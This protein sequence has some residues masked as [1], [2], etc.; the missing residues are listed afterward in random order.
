VLIEGYDAG[1]L[2]MTSYALGCGVPAADAIGSTEASLPTDV[3]PE[4]TNL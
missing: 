3:P 1:S 4:A 2:S